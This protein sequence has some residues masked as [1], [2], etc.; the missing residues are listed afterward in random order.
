[1]ESA[2]IA[3]SA[4]PY[5]FNLELARATVEA[6][7]HLCDLGSNTETVY[8]EL[9]LDGRAR[10]KGVHVIP[11]CGLSPGMTNILA[12]HV[13]IGGYDDFRMRRQLHDFLQCFK[14]TAAGA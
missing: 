5:F 2:D 3:I 11:D 1:M 14:T 4:V 6:G 12:A 9:E 13:D 10:A 7:T 8:R